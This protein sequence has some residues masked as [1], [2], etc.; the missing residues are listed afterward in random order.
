MLEKASRIAGGDH[1]ERPAH[2][3]EEPTAEVVGISGARELST[4][5]YA[6]FY[7][8]TVPRSSD[9]LPRAFG[10]LLLHDDISLEAVDDRVFT[11][12][13]APVLQA[14]TCAPQDAWHETQELVLL[15]PRSRRRLP[16]KSSLTSSSPL[17]V[18]TD[19]R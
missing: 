19:Q 4:G 5:C 15:L 12:P 6:I 17:V 14:K 9:E 10:P 2:P 3:F 1:I 13:F 18:S 8:T 16:R 7:P 11:L